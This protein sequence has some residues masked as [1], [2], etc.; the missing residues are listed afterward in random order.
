MNCR[1][2]HA[3][4][5]VPGPGHRGHPALRQ[6]TWHSRGGKQLA[7]SQFQHDQAGF[8]ERTDGLAGD[9]Q[10]ASLPG[11]PSTMNDTTEM[12]RDD[13]AASV[14]ANRARRAHRRQAP[15]VRAQTASSGAC[16]AG[17]CNPAPRGLQ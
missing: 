17:A 10:A 6:G 7:H 8:N 15:K 12:P 3:R 2:L 1:R 14:A 9:P 5:R 11:A 13:L 4:P 16:E